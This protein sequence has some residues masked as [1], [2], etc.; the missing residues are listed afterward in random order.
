MLCGGSIV[1][2][3]PRPCSINY[4]CDLFVNQEGI[5]K[6]LQASVETEERLWKEKVENAES[7]LQ[8]IRSDNQAL[9]SELNTLRTTHEKTKA[10]LGSYK[11]QAQ[12]N[13]SA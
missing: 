6:K 7:V 4:V 11:S 10:E 5:L 8:Q 3:L 2:N 1:V 13:G 12:Q 9:E